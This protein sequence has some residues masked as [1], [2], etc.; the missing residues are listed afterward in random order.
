VK[1]VRAIG[2]RNEREFPNAEHLVFVTDSGVEASLVFLNE[3]LETIDGAVL[4]KANG[5]RH[6]FRREMTEWKTPVLRVSYAKGD[7]RVTPAPRQPI[8]VEPD[9]VY[10]KARHK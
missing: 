3:L 2:S 7:G 8:S 1:L 6:T 10:R 5:E 9:V 4:L